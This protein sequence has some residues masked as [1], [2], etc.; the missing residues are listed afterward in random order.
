M[1]I[2]GTSFLVGD[3]VVINVFANAQVAQII[4]KGGSTPVDVA[5]RG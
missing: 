5:Y 3:N 4:C 2:Y 1:I